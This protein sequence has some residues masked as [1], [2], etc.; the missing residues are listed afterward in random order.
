[1]TTT[2]GY[3]DTHG[4]ESHPQNSCLIF[5]ELRLARAASSSAHTSP[6]SVGREGEV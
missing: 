4:A 5:S 3:G 6:I 2:A 1:M